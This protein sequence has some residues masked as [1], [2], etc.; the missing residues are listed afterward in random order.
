[1]DHDAS[2]AQAIRSPGVFSMCHGCEQEGEERFSDTLSE[3]LSA[4][5]TPRFDVIAAVAVTE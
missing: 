3:G 2:K 1:L 4:I 5:E